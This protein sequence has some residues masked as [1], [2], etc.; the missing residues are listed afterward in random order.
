MYIF[1]LHIVS[2]ALYKE[3][4]QLK[5]QYELETGTLKKVMERTTQVNN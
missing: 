5:Q 1:F 4:D 2:E 3:Y